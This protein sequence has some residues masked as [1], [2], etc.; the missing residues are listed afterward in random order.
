MND[1]NADHILLDLTMS[2]ALFNA[3]LLLNGAM[4]FQ[5][6]KLCMMAYII[7]T[8]DFY[9]LQKDCLAENSTVWDTCKVVEDWDTI[10]A[11][12]TGNIILHISDIIYAK[13]SEFKITK[14]MWELLQTE[15]SIPH[16]IVTFSLFKS[17]LDLHILSNQHPGKV[18]NQ[19]QI[20][21][22]ELKDTKFELY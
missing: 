11:K 14:E 22:V 16:V 3:V 12:V 18:L 7:S 13:I 9:I 19:L 5:K 21:F 8:R 20:Y 15:Y 1:F 6:W 4:T 2:N 17:I 10:N